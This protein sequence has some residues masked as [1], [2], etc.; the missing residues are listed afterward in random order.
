[1]RIPI[2]ILLC[3]LTSLAST[4]FIWGQTALP[5]RSESR[6]LSE[7]KEK[8]RNDNRDHPVA[9]VQ[10]AE[11]A[12]QEL[13]LRP[14]PESE[15]WFITNLV[16]DLIVLANYPK[17]GAYLE[18]GRKVVAQVH[19]TRGHLLLEIRAAALDLHMGRPSQSKQLLDG[20]LPMFEPFCLRNPQDL[21]VGRGLGTAFRLQGTA[22]QALGRC[23]EAIGAYQKVQNIGAAL[24]DPREQSIAL[25]Q[26]GALYALL[27]RTEEAIAS[28][29]HAIQ[30]AQI[31]GDQSLEAAFHL[32]LAETYRSR[33]EPEA[34]M[35]S[36]NRALELSHKA[37][38]IRF[39]IAGLVNLAD[40][41][42]KKKDYGAALHQADIALKIPGISEDPGM[43]AVCQVNRGIALNRLGNHAEGIE[44]LVRGLS[45]SKTIQDKSQIAE[46]T[47]NLAEECA[48]AGDFRRAYEAAV[49]FKLLSDELKRAAD[50][51]FIAEASAAFESDK[52]LIQIEGLK[53]EKRIQFRLVLLWVAL[54]LLGFSVVGI[55]L[56]GR[57]KL[58]RLN[59]SLGEVNNHNLE[60]IDQLKS[61]LS[62]LRT[63]KGLIPIC[64]HCKKIRDDDGY[65]SQ[66][67]TYIQSRTEAQFTHGMCPE[68]YEQMV[69][70]F[71]H[72]NPN[73]A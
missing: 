58:K 39:Q 16:D 68:C 43:A 10:W 18:R 42:L 31:L 36:L 20:L 27:D 59:A 5:A 13:A 9:S 51:K 11:E 6:N 69:S 24:G 25:N 33:N 38:N 23:S 17:A 71:D 41:F 28:H 2:A 40:V 73:E 32:D 37:G 70:E 50:Q 3:F 61:A 30:M 60:L 15:I 57:K 49:E 52:K 1:M 54:S 12:L 44:A 8:I 72:Y 26:M 22:L 56:V 53:R 45:Q 29:R 55:L 48:F 47:G 4:G 14:D 7:L 46:I 64:A 34:Q 66:M 63:L 65:W 19:S 35:A 21:E 67:E 62:E